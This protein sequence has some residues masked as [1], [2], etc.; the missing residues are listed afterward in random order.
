[1]SRRTTMKQFWV[2]VVLTRVDSNHS[3]LSFVDWN[4][5]SPHCWISHGRR[6]SLSFASLED[7][8]SPKGCSRAY[9]TG[10]TQLIRG[11]P[12]ILL[13]TRDGFL[14]TSGIT[15]SVINLFIVYRMSVWYIQQTNYYCN[16]HYSCYRLLIT[17]LYY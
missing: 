3:C 10:S 6:H 4:V 14:L 2:W 16:C 1:M 8:V 5:I 17:Y 7:H 12:E 15:R 13:Q 11:D 9:G